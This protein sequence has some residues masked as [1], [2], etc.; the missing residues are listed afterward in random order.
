[1][2]ITLP[3][4]SRRHAIVIGSSMAG[5]VT[6]RSLLPYFERVTLIERDALPAGPEMRRGVP[7]AR[8]A[9]VL[10]VR[11][12]RILNDLF[13]GLT[14]ELAAAGAPTVDWSAD[15]AMHTAFG[16]GPR[17]PS[18]MITTTC[19]RPLL[20]WTV[21][22]RLDFGELSRAAAHP[23]VQ[24]LTG[25]DVTA[26]E[27]TT[28]RSRV[29]GV[30][31]RFRHAPPPELNGA[32]SL[33]AGLVVDA[34]GRTS[35]LPAWLQALGY[36]APRETVINSFL[37][38]A[39][40][41]YQKP[42]GFAADWKCLLIAPKPLSN[43]RSAVIYPI[44]NGQ[45]IV[46]LGGI[47][48]VFPPTDEAGFLEFARQLTTPALH[49]AIQNAE[50]LSAIFGYQRTENRWRHYENLTRW[51]VGLAVLGDAVCAFNPVYGQGMTTGA[52]GALALAQCLDAQETRHADVT[53][54]GLPF[55]RALAQVNQTAWL[56]ATGEDFRWPATEG[57]RPSTRTRLL[58]RYMDQVL[59]IASHDA[60]AQHA[61]MQ[62][63]HLVEPPARLFSPAMLR[64]VIGHVAHNGLRAVETA[65]SGR[66][67]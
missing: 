42:A 59:Q 12:Q 63:S 54:I 21:R 41:W 52:L 57:G 67:A 56:M 28:D 50:P 32:T 4:D 48:R 33:A 37:G 20:E 64:R 44:E 66:P 65:P 5:L 31:L 49:D 62:V 43:P 1:M 24:F 35:Q 7:Q 36:E 18:D 19:S 17:Q 30:H 11:G 10:L 53:S 26:L 16:W 38:Y 14:T 61:F 3:Q 60:F 58:H 2:T 29:T 34:S 27:T 13:P 23:Q 9:H 8:H 39:S 55:Q 6:A 25:A 47:N 22:Q 46:T 51:P 15:C 45:W 40:R